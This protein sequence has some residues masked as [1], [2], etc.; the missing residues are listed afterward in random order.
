MLGWVLPSV[1]AIIAYLM[2]DQLSTC[3]RVR[4][5]RGAAL[6]G[7]ERSEAVQ[8]N[9]SRLFQILLVSTRTYLV[10]WRLEILGACV[11]SF[12]AV[13]LLPEPSVDLRAHLKGT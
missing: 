4:N 9:A 6:R 5:P 1:Y 2:H 8:K 11:R 10:T 12:R 7:G 3:R 13:F